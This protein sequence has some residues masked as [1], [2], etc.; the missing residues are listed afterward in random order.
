MKTFWYIIEHGDHSDA[1]ILQRIDL[2]AISLFAFIGFFA[3]LWLAITE[4]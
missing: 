4:F 3:L 1:R 2:L